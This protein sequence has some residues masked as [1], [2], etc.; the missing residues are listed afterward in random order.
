MVPTNMLA[1]INTAE[2]TAAEPDLDNP[3][4]IAWLNV[5]EHDELAKCLNMCIDHW[6]NASP[7]ARKKM[8][9]LFAIA[10][11]FLAMCC[12]GHVLAMCDMIQSGELYVTFLIVL[13]PYS[14]LAIFSMKYQ[15]AVVDCLL[16]LYGS[17]IGLAYDIMCAFIKTVT[18]SSLGAKVVG[19]CL[20]G[21]V[22]T[23]HRHAHNCGCQINWLPLYVEGAGLEDFEECK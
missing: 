10:G 8:Y 12:H 18:R 17:D 13:Q 5:A 21:V 15:I 14:N 22:P 4:K 3:E 16:E 23:F 19:L 20:P 1:F 9:A 7:E 11:I 6:R 2:D